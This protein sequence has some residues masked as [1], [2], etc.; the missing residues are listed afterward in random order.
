M[1]RS[2]KFGDV[3]ASPRELD[4]AN[5]WLRKNADAIKGLEDA[6]HLR[7]A[8]ATAPPPPPTDPTCDFCQSPIFEEY[9]YAKQPEYCTRP[10][11]QKKRRKFE[12]QQEAVASGEFDL[13]ACVDDEEDEGEDPFES[14]DAVSDAEELPEKFFAE[15][16]VQPEVDL[17]S[18]S[19]AKDEE[20]EEEFEDDGDAFDDEDEGLSDEVS[21]DD[22]EEDDEKSEDNPEGTSTT[23]I[24]VK[25]ERPKKIRS[26]G[27]GVV[28]V[29]SDFSG[30]DEVP[31]LV[32][33][34]NGFRPPHKGTKPLLPGV[35]FFSTKRC[36]AHEIDACV[37]CFPV[38]NADIVERQKVID[39]H[40]DQQDA[41]RWAE[42]V[43]RGLAPEPPPK[44]EIEAIERE[45]KRI[46]KERIEKEE[47]ERRKI[48]KKRRVRPPKPKETPNLRLQYKFSTRQLADVMDVLLFNKKFQV[49]DRSLL[50]DS[51]PKT[52]TIYRKWYTQI[53]ENA[54]ERGVPIR[55]GR[56]RGDSRYENL[57][58][59]QEKTEFEI[60]DGKP[61]VVSAGYVPPE[62]VMID[63]VA[64][65]VDPVDVESLAP[66]APPAPPKTVTEI[67][68]D[69]STRVHIVKEFGLPD[70][71]KRRVRIESPVQKS[72][73]TY[74]DLIN[75]LTY[76]WETM[77][78]IEE[79][80]FY[81]DY[82]A[83]NLTAKQ[84]DEKHGEKTDE[85]ILLLEN[86]AIRHAFKLRLLDPP[87]EALYREFELDLDEDYRLD[88][89]M[90]S[91]SG[92]GYIG[93]HV[94]GGKLDRYGRTMK[95]N[96]FRTRPI[97]ET[98]GGS[99]EADNGAPDYDS[100]GDESA[101]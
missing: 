21:D 85:D 27:E 95:L 75:A 72:P 63:G 10:K 34:R 23:K 41:E 76:R 87:L 20:G 28:P 77:L 2:K 52:K 98:G 14:S 89:L 38:S 69:G 43:R 80:A 56:R 66:P 99:S 97:R 55:Q 70:K 13:I 45:A 24:K 62:I 90:V 73:S 37:K 17:K 61:V 29:A 4:E 46:E 82:A 93:G 101:A 18:S 44:D 100:F 40:R 88:A 39:A 22:S 26:D 65:S 33:I 83:R 42:L 48:V 57:L 92:G 54:A 6:K 8:P 67:L 9:R 32:R 31:L 96:S 3:V 30:D 53:A 25:R 71:I 1:S 16:S 84:L 68:P 49:R 64:V 36:H 78:T 94:T 12:L 91:K 59:K 51:N 58:D 50:Y 11:C 5:D 47:K 60:I 86:R 81:R 19:D 79:R 35:E 15:E 74:G 7:P